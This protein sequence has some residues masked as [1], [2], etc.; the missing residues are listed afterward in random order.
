[1]AWS[2]HL[3]MDQS[4]AYRLLSGARVA[5]L[6]TVTP[7]GRP[8]VVPCCFALDGHTIYSA[9]DTVKP[10]ST[11]ALQRLANLGGNPAASLLVHHY[12]E[13]WTTL[14]WVRVDGLGRV[15]ETDEERGRGVGLLA[16]K[17]FQYEDTPPP[18]EVLALDI[19]RWR[20]WP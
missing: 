1:M 3:S 15:V 6:A 4:A 17:Y 9:V 12:T 18:G 20:S 10:K 13:D 16:A 5:T 11:M 8:H 19:E 14:W 2:Y 7:K